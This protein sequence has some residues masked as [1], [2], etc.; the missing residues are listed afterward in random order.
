M[1]GYMGINLKG[2]EIFYVP[3][4]F[5][6]NQCGRSIVVDSNPN[7]LEE[8]GLYCL[9]NPINEKFVDVVDISEKML[10]EFQAF[11]ENNHFN[12][13]QKALE[14]F[15]LAKDFVQ[16]NEADPNKNFVRYAVN[17]GYGNLLNKF[18]E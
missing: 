10:S 5:I 11:C 3:R 2:E 16:L 7:H 9:E 4:N 18:T 17:Q 6:L 8:L 13:Y 12:S 1:K 14:I 15:D